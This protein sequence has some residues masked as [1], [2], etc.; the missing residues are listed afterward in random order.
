MVYTVVNGHGGE[1]ALRSR[2]EGGAVARMALPLVPP[3]LNA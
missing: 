1:I 2:P 3:A